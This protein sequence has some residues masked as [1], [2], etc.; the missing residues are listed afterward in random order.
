MRIIFTS[1][2]ALLLMGVTAMYFYV[3]APIQNTVRVSVNQTIAPNVTGA[4]RVALDNVV[5]ILEFD[6]AW[7]VGIVML[8]VVAWWILSAVR[9]DPESYTIGG[10]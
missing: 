1:L 2:V 7:I 3:V 6:Y 10:V 9:R 8:G 4:A 5:H